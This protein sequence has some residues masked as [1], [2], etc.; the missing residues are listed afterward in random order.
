M[1]I[2]AVT[3]PI[4]NDRFE[5]SNGTFS[6]VIWSDPPRRRFRS[7]RSRHRPRHSRLRRRHRCGSTRHGLQKDTSGN[8][9]RFVNTQ[10]LLSKSL[11]LDSLWDVCPSYLHIVPS[12]RESCCGCSPVLSVTANTHIFNNFEQFSACSRGAPA[13]L[14]PRAKQLP[15]GVTWRPT[16]PELAAPPPQECILVTYTHSRAIYTRSRAIR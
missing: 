14:W 13:R 5:L 4:R 12:R 15:S 9:S 16:N 6:E 1:K 7:T 2:S 11:C 3:S 10:L 8:E